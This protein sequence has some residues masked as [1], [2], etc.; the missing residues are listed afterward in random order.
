M[1]YASVI[2]A[3]SQNVLKW[4]HTTG[5][6]SV[7]DPVLDLHWYMLAVVDSTCIKTDIDTV[8]PSI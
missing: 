4:T 6:T 2:V 7:S 5:L 1:T 3:H 8:K